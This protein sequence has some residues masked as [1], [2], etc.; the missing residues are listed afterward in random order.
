MLANSLN[1]NQYFQQSDDL[2]AHYLAFTFTFIGYAIGF[3][4]L[5][6]ANWWVNIFGV[7]V[8]TEALIISAY[9]LHEFS[10]RSIF[11]T[12]ALNRRW[13][14]VMTWI[15]G[16]CYNTFEEIRD[17][18]MHHHVDRADVISFDI[19]HFIISL[20]RP[21]NKLVKALEWAYIPVAE[22]IMHTMVVVMPFITPAWQH[23]RARIVLIVLVRGALF[24]L[25][26][27]VS[28]KAWLLY[29]LAY[30]LMLTA[31]R[32][33]DAYQHTYDVFVSLDSGTNNKLEFIDGKLR[34]RTYEQANTY[35]N[36]TSVAHPW[37]NLL[38]LNFP[39]HNAH[40]ERPVVAWNQLPQLHEKLYGK[41]KTSTNSPASAAVIP[42]MTLLK[43]YHR[44]RLTRLESDDYGTLTF[45]TADSKA[46]PKQLELGGADNFIGA[47]GVSFLTAI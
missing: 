28:M 2:S 39:Y 24:G 41:A 22:I 33:A 13:G 21:L 44:H 35:S 10:H 45:K 15:N 42:M 47:V 18:H 7:V 43:S 23:K 20:P 12:A 31:L 29:V 25:I 16:S 34:D 8:L 4:S 36:L 3:A 14:I 11:K 6:T 37:L 17:K 26:A 32:F 27:W 5:F 19:K 1:F 30:C 46:E 9:L 38:F 40:H